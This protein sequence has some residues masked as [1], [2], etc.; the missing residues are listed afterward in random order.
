M[1]SPAGTTSGAAPGTGFAAQA[2]A[3][4]VPA[5]P[6]AAGAAT[7]AANTAAAGTPA[8]QAVAAPS[9][10]TA[11]SAVAQAAQVAVAAAQAALASSVQLSPQAQQAVRVEAFTQLVAQ[12]VQQV[13]G[14]QLPATAWPANGVPPAVQALLSSLVQQATAGQ[15]LP[16]QLVSVQAWPQSLLQAVL[17]QAG[18]AG[19]E[20][21]SARPAVAAGVLPSALPA[22]PAGDAAQAGAGQ[23][24]TVS[25]PALQNWLVLQGS[26]QAQDGVRSM[27]LTLKVPQAWAQAQAALA[28]ALAAAGTRAGAA[29]ASI[30]GGGGPPG[31]A[32]APATSLG[33]AAP[34]PGG[35]QLP[36]LQLAFAGSLQ[37]LNSSAF[38]LV[39]QPQALPGTPPAIQAQLQQLR[40]SAVLQLELQ[41]QPHQAAQQAVQAAAAYTPAQ[42]V[43]QEWQ[44][45][46]Q[47]RVTDPW[48]QMAQLHASG[49]QGRQQQ[50]AGEQPGLCVVEGCQYMGRAVCAQ[51]FCAEMNYLWSVAR[52]QSRV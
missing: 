1:A 34:P 50:H 42:L 41:P 2:Q 30:P 45:L 49:Q 25:I 43:P 16:Q 32:L 6:A 19:Q 21:G 12:L 29:A 17:L 9:A 44:A 14:G 8:A 13:S 40:T 24:A 46:L 52:A 31:A 27:S 28:A 37:Q 10:V 48:V 33:F 23:R 15:A 5:Q 7:P 4:G 38:G 36:G 20:G 47:G 22:A 3:Q 26:I 39:L 18:Q 11:S 51:P 35:W